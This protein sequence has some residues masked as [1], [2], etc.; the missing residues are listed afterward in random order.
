MILRQYSG[1]RSHFNGAALRPIQIRAPQSHQSCAEDPLLYEK[2]QVAEFPLAAI[3]PILAVA[4]LVMAWIWWYT[5]RQHLAAARQ[6]V[7]RLDPH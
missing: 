3:I 1:E 5:V 4:G 2:A 7:L 6:G